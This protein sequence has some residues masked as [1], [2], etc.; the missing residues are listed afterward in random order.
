MKRFKLSEAGDRGW[1]IGTFERSVF[2]T[3]QFEVAY[4]FNTAGD[5][6]RAHYHKV[7]TEINLVTHGR[8]LVNDDI[9]VAGEGFIMEPGDPCQCQYLEDT[10]T[11]VVK[12]PAMPNDKYYI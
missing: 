6:S 4:G 3:D 8:V 11:L 9:F 12:V 1:F 10:H 2:K 7:S 5:T